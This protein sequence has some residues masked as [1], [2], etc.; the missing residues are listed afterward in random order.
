MP[1]IEVSDEI[2]MRVIAYWQNVDPELGARLASA[3]G[4]NGGAEN[5]ASARAAEVV[6]GRANRA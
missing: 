1:A 2:Q 3:L 5:G 6:A 4:R